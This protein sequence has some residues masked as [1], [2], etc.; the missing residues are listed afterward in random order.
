M[1][2]A[3]ALSGSIQ[4]LAPDLTAE[5]VNATLKVQSAGADVDLV[6]VDSEPNGDF[7]LIDVKPTLPLWVGVGP[8][9]GDPAST[10]VD[11]LQPVATPLTL[12]VQLVV[13][14][15]DLLDAIVEAFPNG[16]DATRGHAILRFVDATRAGISGVALV[17]PPAATTDVAYDFGLTYSDQVQ[18]TEAGGTIVLLNLPSV[19]YPGSVTT[20]GVTLHG[21]R[22][23][24]PV[25]LA[26]GAVTVVTTVLPR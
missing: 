9:T 1:G 19:A 24:V 20:I 26:N 4:A 11:T 14:P 17:S 22:H 25:Q 18:A 8:F 12:P 2:T 10:F 7:R 21:T 15:R 23:D 5:P 13:L 16:I 3:A 6:S